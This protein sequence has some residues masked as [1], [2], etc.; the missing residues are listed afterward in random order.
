MR[1]STIELKLKTYAESAGA[2]FRKFNSA[3][4]RGVCD[5]LVFLNGE[6]LALEVK[7][8]GKAPTQLQRYRLREFLEVGV[9]ATWCDSY[10]SGRL[11]L[12]LFIEYGAA[13]VRERIDS[14]GDFDSAGL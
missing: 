8:P 3:A 9:P 10:E 1:E 7:A 6:V 5:D 11:V 4:T 14:A 13:E 2:L 12:D